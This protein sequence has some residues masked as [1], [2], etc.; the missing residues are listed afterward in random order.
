MRL[1]AFPSGILIWAARLFGLKALDEGC[2]AKR[3]VQAR[4]RNSHP[5]SVSS[6]L[7]VRTVAAHHHTEEAEE[8]FNKLRPANKT[9]QL[10]Q[11]W[12]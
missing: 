3:A 4:P 2:H 7:K 8:E 6:A 1:L 5:D 9:D 11:S 10:C 12:Q